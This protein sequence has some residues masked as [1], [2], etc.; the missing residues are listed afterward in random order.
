VEVLLL[1]GE[2]A[3]AQFEEVKR[4]SSILH[5]ED[6]NYEIATAVKDKGTASQ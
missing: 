6:I 3:T 2:I 4:P 5:P 1:K